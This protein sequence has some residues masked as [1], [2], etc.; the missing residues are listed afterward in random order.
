MGTSTW[1]RRLIWPQACPTIFFT[2]LS[3]PALDNPAG[4]VYLLDRRF[5]DPRRPIIPP[6]QKP[7][8]D[9]IAEALPPYAPELPVM[10]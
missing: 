2:T 9:Q 7:T 5:L 3:V 4:Q 6:G 8:P 1:E 10:G